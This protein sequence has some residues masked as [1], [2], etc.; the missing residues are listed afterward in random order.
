MRI[1]L[2]LSGYF[3]SFKDGSSTGQDGYEYIKKHI[4]NCA[5]P[6]CEVDVF[7][8]N[9]EPHLEE[10]ITEL[11]QPK[12]YIVESQIDFVEIA[13]NN[14]VSRRYLDPYNQLGSWTMTSKQGAGYVGPERLLSQYYSTQKSIELKRT[15]E[16]ENDFKYDCVIKSRFDLGRINRSTSGPGKA[17]PYACQC[18]KFDPTLDM[19]KLYMVYWDLFNEGPADMWFYSSSENMDN[20]CELYHKVLKEYL[21]VES[22]YRRTVMTGWPESKLD[23]FRTN[24]MFKP[25]VERAENLHR[26]PPFLTVNGILLMKWF[27]MDTGLW[28]KAT[29][30]EAEWE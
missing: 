14:K 10:K 2:C 23:D 18:I 12:K 21:Q 30:L 25:Q 5:S 8:H 1:A 16:E 27:F 17:N 6:T 19:S 13:E 24:E 11:Y 22:E 20:F 9:W 26:Y 4:L 28:K 29:A 3:D 7:F 15:Y